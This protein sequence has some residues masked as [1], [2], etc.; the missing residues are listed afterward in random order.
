VSGAVGF[1]VNEVDRARFPDLAQSIDDFRSEWDRLGTAI[2]EVGQET[3]ESSG[4]MRSATGV[5][6]DLADGLSAL[7]EEHSQLDEVL[8]VYR[9]DLARLDE[10]QRANIM[11][12]LEYATA[13]TGFAEV[14]G[15][16]EVAT[17]ALAA[18]IEE[19]NR[20]EQLNLYLTREAPAAN[21][22]A[23]K[24]LQF[25]EAQRREAERRA[26]EGARSA[27]QRAAAEARTRREGRV[28]GGS[29]RDSAMSIVQQMGERSAEDF[30]AGFAASILSSAQDVAQSYADQIKAQLKPQE[31]GEDIGQ[32]V[33]HGLYAATGAVNL[34]G[35]AIAFSLEDGTNR[36]VRAMSATFDWMAQ[37]L[38]IAVGA[39]LVDTA[40]GGL[41]GG[42]LGLFSAVSS[43]ASYFGGG[44]SGGGSRG[45]ASRARA[46]S[47][48]PI[49]PLSPE[50]A[51]SGGATVIMYN[52][53][54]PE[55]FEGSEVD[56]RFA[57]TMER[58]ARRRQTWMQEQR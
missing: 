15:R 21:A 32:S 17:R 22:L 35:D 40:T 54:A 49:A 57:R 10:T 45:T 16:M 11:T 1:F 5:V 52:L 14:H 25:N 9:D 36:G 29:A 46:T 55:F 2:R 44:G 58:A 3:L 19:L 51:A 23:E 31:L 8:R 56:R 27:E 24:E 42:I 20:Q 12:L 13:G 53:V 30:A 34:L 47:S 38:Q 33:A 4:L 6:R 41:L 26:R 39:G 28:I 48:R 7:S 37:G 18:A 50:I 43:L